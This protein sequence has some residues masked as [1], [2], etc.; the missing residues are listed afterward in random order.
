MDQHSQHYSN[1]HNYQNWIV[2]IV[3]L[4]QVLLERYEAI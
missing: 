3:L 1:V 2:H 4:H